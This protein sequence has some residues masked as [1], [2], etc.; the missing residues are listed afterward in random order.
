MV[1]GGYYSI[2]GNNTS[3]MTRVDQAKVRLQLPA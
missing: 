2:G 1:K 3:N